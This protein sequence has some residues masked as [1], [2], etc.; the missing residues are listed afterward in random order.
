MPC[1]CSKVREVQ[2]LA[3]FCSSGPVTPPPV[4]TYADLGYQYP[5]FGSK[6]SSN[7]LSKFED[8]S[9]FEKTGCN[10]GAHNLVTGLDWYSSGGADRIA[11]IKLHYKSELTWEG[12]LVV[13][14]EMW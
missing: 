13:C 12:L 4:D 1:S 9:T 14:Q 5:S 2:G 10:G 11:N 7:A 8:V 6:P 3:L